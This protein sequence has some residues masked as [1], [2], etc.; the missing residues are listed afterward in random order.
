MKRPDPSGDPMHVKL[1]CDRCG[2]A[3][4][5]AFSGLRCPRFSACG[6]GGLVETTMMRSSMA[7]LGQ[8]ANSE[9]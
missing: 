5:P 3:L 8:K 1:V 2:T 6:R 9:G 7:W 4:A